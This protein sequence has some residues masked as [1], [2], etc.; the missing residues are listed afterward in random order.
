MTVFDQ[1]VLMYEKTTEEN[2]SHA[3]KDRI[4]LQQAVNIDFHLGIGLGVRVESQFI[5]GLAAR[6]T[7]F[8]I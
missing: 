8:V 5:Y 4:T 6:E 3:Y 7:E 2:H 1:D